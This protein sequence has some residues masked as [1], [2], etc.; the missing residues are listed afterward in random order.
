[1][2]CVGGEGR[3][4]IIS[5]VYLRTL[6]VESRWCGGGRGM[7]VESVTKTCDRMCVCVCLGAED[8]GGG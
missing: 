8:G 1:M 4:D 2:K 7:Q 6:V 5:D 3:E